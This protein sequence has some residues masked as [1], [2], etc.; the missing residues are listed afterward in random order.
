MLHYKADSEINIY[1][2][3]TTGKQLIIPGLED[4][5]VKSHLGQK[6]GINILTISPKDDFY[7][8]DCNFVGVVESSLEG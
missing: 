1:I 4:H 2:K 5:N 6:G 8:T 3:K 7:C